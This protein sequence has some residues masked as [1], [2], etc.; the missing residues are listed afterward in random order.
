MQ[1]LLNLRVQEQSE[2]CKRQI[3]SF[4]LKILHL[5]LKKFLGSSTAISL[6]ETLNILKK[7]VVG[8]H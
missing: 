6:A 8:R 1:F 3:P 4:R 5:R 7:F 2:R